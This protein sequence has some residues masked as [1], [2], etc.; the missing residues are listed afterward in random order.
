MQEKAKSLSPLAA[1][2]AWFDK[3][4]ATVLAR[5]EIYEQV[6]DSLFLLPADIQRAVDIAVRTDILRD[7]MRSHPEEWQQAPSLL[8]SPAPLIEIIRGLFGEAVPVSVA[9]LALEAI[10]R[11]D[12]ASHAPDAAV[13]EELNK[14]EDE[15]RSI[16]LPT[17]LW[18]VEIEERGRMSVSIEERDAVAT[19][20]RGLVRAVDLR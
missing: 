5:L 1:E 11:E 13:G 19:G 8:S 18:T 12:E 14:R 16:G 20:F 15:R 3:W 6:F 4:T 2:R 9:V 7:A 10:L 17:Y